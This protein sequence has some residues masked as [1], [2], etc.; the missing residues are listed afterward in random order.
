[1]PFRPQDVQPAQAY[2]LVVLGVGL[3]LE[4]AED[5]LVVLLVG[6]PFL[7]VH[8]EHEVAIVVP[9]A[10]GHLLAGQV[11]GVAPQQDV[12]AAAGH[13]G[14]NRDRPYPAR[15]GNDHG[16]LLVLLRVQ[17]V[18]GDP[19]AVEVA[20]ELLGLLDRHRA[21]EHR[22]AG[23]APLGDVLD[24]GVPLRVL[25]L[26]D[27]VLLVRPDHRLVRGDLHHVELV[28]L[29]ELRELGLG[30]TGHAGELLVHLEVVLDGDRG[31][32]L[33]LLFDPDVLLGLDGLVESLRIPPALQDP[34]GELVDDLHLAAGHDV[35]HVALVQ[36]LGSER[37]LE[38]VHERRVD[39]LVQVLDAEG[40]LD[41]PDALLRDGHGAFG[42]IDLV[43]GLRLQARGEASER[44][45]PLGRV[46]HHA[47]D[48]QRGPGLVDQDRVHLVHD[49]VV[50]AAL[51]H[52]LPAHGHVGPQ[53][54]EPELVVGPGRDVGSIGRSA[55]GRCH[56]SLD[57]PQG[58][59]HRPVDRSHPLRVTLGQVVVHRDDVHPL[60]GQGVQVSGHGRH[61][62]L[63]FARLHLGDV[64]LVQDDG[65]HHL[66][67]EVS[68]ADRAPSGLADGGERLGEQV[69]QALTGLQAPPK[70]LG[71]RP[72]LL[73]GELL[74]LGLERV[75]DAD[76]LLEALELAALAELADLLQAQS[77]FLA[78]FGGS[79][80]DCNGGVGQ[81]LGRPQR[82]GVGLR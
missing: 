21:D 32:G 5:R 75:D 70:L 59:A 80:L 49:P 68:L 25:D 41:L 11:L 81:A 22:L 60:P 39:V 19:P 61:Q 7:L 40:L 54:V 56:R 26:V 1:M 27:E 47:T 31:Q 51:H 29:L 65:P 71:L 73:V 12:D 43:V 18:M 82:V 30:R 16:L 66:D 36:L 79:A 74:E 50:M 55:F 13:V 2:D 34:A 48:D 77:R 62:G 24:H 15:L 67:V 69:V 37:V 8:L 23:L 72:E 4:L 53:V 76:E 45:V 44:H 20:G 3:L 9:L 52:V 14:G 57:E 64:A 28:D 78:W 58:G 63:A 17:D 35:V 6:G 38:V 10:R 42:L 46:G 33:V